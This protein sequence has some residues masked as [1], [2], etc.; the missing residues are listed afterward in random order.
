MKNK[1]K[2]VTFAAGLLTWGTVV[3]GQDTSS[4]TAPASAVPATTTQT[5]PPSAVPQGAASSATAQSNAPTNGG[6]AAKADD[7][8]KKVIHV[9][10]DYVKKLANYGYY[11]KNAKGELVFCKKQTPLGTHF[12]REVCMDGEQLSMFLEKAE[13]QREEM[14]RRICVGGLDCGGG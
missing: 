11:P 10:T 13:A 14:R 3:F 2:V 4:A 7:K 8:A 9:S 5:P 1:V 6:D 12:A